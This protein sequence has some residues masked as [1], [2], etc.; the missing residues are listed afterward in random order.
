MDRETLTGIV[1]DVVR[2]HAPTFAGPW[3]LETR[4]GSDGAGIDS[5]GCLEII[6]ELEARTSIVLRDESL[7]AESLTT[8]GSLVEYLVAAGP[9]SNG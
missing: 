3:S 2:E 8:I 4:L 5:V 6:L 9:C 7:T 1:V